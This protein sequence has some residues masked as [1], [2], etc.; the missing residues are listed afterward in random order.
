MANPPL[1]E[2]HKVENWSN[3]PKSC[4]NLFSHRLVAEYWKYLLLASLRFQLCLH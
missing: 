1:D 3:T 2:C 4:N